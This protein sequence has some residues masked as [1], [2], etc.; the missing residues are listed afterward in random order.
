MASAIF[1]AVTGNKA[2]TRGD[3][4][5][6]T[7]TMLKDARLTVDGAP[8]AADCPLLIGAA[9]RLTTPWDDKSVALAVDAFVAEL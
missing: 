7:H 8:V 9:V 3:G 6:W 4:R 1:L 5:E 2:M